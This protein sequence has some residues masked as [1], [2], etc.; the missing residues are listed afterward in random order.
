MCSSWVQKVLKRAHKFE[1]VLRGCSSSYSQIKAIFYTRKQTPNTPRTTTFV[2]ITTLTNL[3][4]QT[5]FP[6]NENPTFAVLTTRTS[7]GH[8]N[9]FPST[10]RITTFTFLTTRT[11]LSH[12][13]RF[14]NNANHRICVSNKAH[15]FK[16]SDS[17]PQ[18]REPPHSLF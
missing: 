3:G 15:E 9:R 10:T 17:I 4:R 2:Y 7:S 8:Q 13:T 1:K 18:P 14:P 12:H 16:P 6:D 5:R 11:S